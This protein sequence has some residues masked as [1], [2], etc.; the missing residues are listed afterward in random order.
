MEHISMSTVAL[1]S[2]WSFVVIAIIYCHS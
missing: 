2:H 1:S